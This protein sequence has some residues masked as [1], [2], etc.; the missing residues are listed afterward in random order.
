M[1]NKCRGG[2][3]ARLELTEPLDPFPARVRT[4]FI[5]D[6]V[7]KPFIYVC[8]FVYCH[9]LSPSCTFSDEH[10]KCLLKVC[11]GIIRCGV[12]S[13]TVA[14]ELLEKDYFGKAI[15]RQLTIKQI[16]N[17]LK[18]ERRLIRNKQPPFWGRPLYA[19]DKFFISHESLRY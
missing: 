1:P 18:Y 17:R 14:K 3:W 10:R 15:L 13:Q 7:F 19:P 9:S 6:V 12:I 4:S 8:V 5:K 2:G 11:G 16:I